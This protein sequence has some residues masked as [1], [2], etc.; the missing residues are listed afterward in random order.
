MSGFGMPTT[1]E[2]LN[3]ELRA[4]DGLIAV[5]P[6]GI[7]LLRDTLLE[8]GRVDDGGRAAAVVLGKGLR[9]PDR[10]LEKGANILAGLL[11]VDRGRGEA[12]QN[13]QH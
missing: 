13:E 12:D 4:H 8:L 5:G 3:A 10:A 11:G 7:R 6:E 1:S 9:T 2:G